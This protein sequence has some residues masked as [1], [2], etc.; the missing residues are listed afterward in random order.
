MAVSYVGLLSYTLQFSCSHLGKLYNCV[1]YAALETQYKILCIS[2][3]KEAINTQD[4]SA[5]DPVVATIISLALDE[6]RTS[7]LNIKAT[8]I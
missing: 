4:C 5:R 7:A 3:I 6:V 2:A 1:E 8:Y